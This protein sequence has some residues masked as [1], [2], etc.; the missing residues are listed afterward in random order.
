[1]HSEHLRPRGAGAAGARPQWDIR[2]TQQ[3]PGEASNPNSLGYTNPTGF[4]R[5]HVEPRAAQFGFVPPAPEPADPL[6]PTY[7]TT[8]DFAEDFGG[9]KVCDAKPGYPDDNKKDKRPKSKG[10][11]Q[12]GINSV[13]LGVVITLGLIVLM[14]MGLSA[15]GVK[16]FQTQ[17]RVPLS[18]GVWLSL[19][20][21]QKVH[22]LDMCLQRPPGV[23]L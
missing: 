11:A 3:L 2:P 18:P 7:R 6:P 12:G 14:L 1:M 10:G 23:K 16:L 5:P 4:A 21:L 13:L 19:R 15:S 9:G 20:C 17:V 22:A 8:G